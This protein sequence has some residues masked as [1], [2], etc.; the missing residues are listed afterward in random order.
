MDVA[1]YLRA[2]ARAE[3]F[4]ASGRWAEAAERWREVTDLNPVNGNHQDRLA[5]ACFEAGDY[6]AAL[7]ASEKA[8]GLG[9]WDRTQERDTAFAG[10][11]E[12]RVACCH[13]RLGDG[14]Q[15]ITELECALRAGL[16]DLDRVR[17]D[18][19][20]QPLLGHERFRAML[21]VDVSGLSRDQGWRS[22]LRLLGREVKRRAYDPF[23]HISEHDFDVMLERLD[24]RVPQLSDAQ[25]LAGILKLLRPLEDGHARI[26]DGDYAPFR[27]ALPAEFYLFAEG[28]FVTAAAPGHQHV[29]GAQVTAFGGRPVAEVIDALDPIISRDN[30]YQARSAATRWLRCP[31]ILHALDL[32]P[33][34]DAVTL[35]LRL[36]DGT[37]AEHPME[38]DSS[39]PNLLA[40]PRPPGWL[41]LEETLPGPVPRYLRNRDLGYWFEYLSAERTLYFQLNSVADHP[42]E[43]LQ[44]FSERLS[45]FIS[46]H[47]AG[48]LVIDLRWNGGGNTFLTQPLLHHLIGSSKINQPG[49]LF[50]IIGR[51]TFSAAQNTATAIERHTRAI[52]VGEPTGSSRNFT[53][54]FV[55]FKLPYSKLPVNVSDLYWQTS[56][57]MDRR[58]WIAP[59]IYTPPTYSDYHAGR[60]PAMD[61]IATYRE[62]LPGL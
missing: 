51:G 4:T 50:V 21:D 13:A 59:E 36:L 52:F 23:R 12:Y 19:S 39:A 53:G 7:A 9:V 62:H 58:R 49:S 30:E 1:G 29:L 40:R 42:A 31:S 8:R 54:E 3:S 33:A 32:I 46:D 55:P 47:D 56:W 11:L 14:E 28:L 37:T 18:P 43:T 5:H 38:A 20:W 16:R 57:P 61:A 25:I 2:L 22:D 34:P 48:T 26:A 35:S 60:D 45:A 10:E 6:P 17:A 44:A 24:C 41:R 15:A 27:Q